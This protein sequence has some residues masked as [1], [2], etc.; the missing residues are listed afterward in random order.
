MNDIEI[1]KKKEKELVTAWRENL[2]ENIENEE[3]IKTKE[4]NQY[5][6]DE[7]LKESFNV[8]VIEISMKKDDRYLPPLEIP[9]E[10]KDKIKNQPVGEAFTYVVINKDNIDRQNKIIYSTG[11]GHLVYELY[12]SRITYLDSDFNYCYEATNILGYS[13]YDGSIKSN[14][15]ERFRSHEFTFKFKTEQFKDIGLELYRDNKDEFNISASGK[16]KVKTIKFDYKKKQIKASIVNCF[17]KNI[18]FDLDGNILSI[19]IKNKLSKELILKKTQFDVNS[20]QQLINL[21]ETELEVHNLM[22]DGDIDIINQKI[23]D[24]QVFLVKNIIKEKNNIDNEK[25]YEH[26]DFIRKFF[27]NTK[28]DFNFSISGGREIV[29]VIKDTQY[30]KYLKREDRDCYHVQQILVFLASLKHTNQTFEDFYNIDVI[31]AFEYLNE[32]STSFSKIF[33]LKTT[34]KPVI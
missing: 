34:T 12:G 32:K 7:I 27:N 4:I 14:S 20:Y 3:I 1:D 16:N 9:Q 23:F 33:N 29:P 5:L 10:I 26:V 17:I 8:E 6:K 18:I 2:F 19:G 28:L 25:I 30:N 21:I 13:G 22:T 24:S 31:N 15:F 11:T